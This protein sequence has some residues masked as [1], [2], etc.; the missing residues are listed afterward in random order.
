MLDS[1]ILLGAAFDEVLQNN[2]KQNSMEPPRSKL[3]C[4]YQ[5]NKS[6]NENRITRSLTIYRRAALVQRRR[7]QSITTLR[8]DRHRREKQSHADSHCVYNTRA[9]FIICVTF[10]L[11]ELRAI[12]RKP[13]IWIAWGIVLESGRCVCVQLKNLSLVAT[14]FLCVAT[15]R[16]SFFMDPHIIGSIF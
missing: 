12:P 4:N 10:E 2:N 1:L 11:C 9:E 16:W 3:T 7:R 15:S 13:G 5:S 14:Y 6:K 8:F